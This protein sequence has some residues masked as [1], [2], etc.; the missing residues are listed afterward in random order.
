MITD[1]ALRKSEEL[2]AGLDALGLPDLSDKDTLN[3]LEELNP[4][5]EPLSTS[6]SAWNWPPNKPEIKG[7]MSDTVE[8]PRALLEIFADSWAKHMLLQRDQAAARESKAFQ[9]QYLELE[10]EGTSSSS[11]S[12]SC[13]SPA[14]S[15]ASTTV[16]SPTQMSQHR[17]SR[18][19]FSES[20]SSPKVMSRSTATSLT[21]SPLLAPRCL[22]DSCHGQ[23]DRGQ[24]LGQ[25]GKSQ[26]AS[27]VNAEAMRIMS[28][29]FHTSCAPASDRVMPK[30]ASVRS[31]LQ[32]PQVLPTREEA[33]PDAPMFTEVS[34]L[35]PRWA[36]H[37]GTR[38]A[39]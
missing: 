9:H 35:G 24:P 21:Q 17:S 19:T 27:S 36:A 2:L 32:A 13:C 1:S 14:D 12:S 18:I 38:S 7:T 33:V 8:V 11:R 4:Y 34:A 26:P 23:T 39:M 29:L 3:S 10:H 15:R 22:E 25:S 37:M 20:P 6:P 28:K 31:Q 16:H 30:Q 5:D